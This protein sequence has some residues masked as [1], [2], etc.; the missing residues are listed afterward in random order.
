MWVA[1][2]PSNLLTYVRIALTPAIVIALLEGHCGRALWLSFAAAATDGLDGL[3]ARRFEWESRLGAYLDP[4]ADKA[5]LTSVYLCLGAAAL[6]PAW[7][8]WLVVGRDVL[9]LSMTVAAILF[10]PF[11][12]FPPSVWGKISTAIQIA[13]ALATLWACA[14]PDSSA[15]LAVWPLVVLTAIATSWSGLDYLR[16]GLYRLRDRTT[17]RS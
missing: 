4:V 12:S 3:L 5:L 15:N 16:R 11:R 1:L 14:Y 13:A 6:M 8:V 17:L 10:T 2:Y 7:L 9:I